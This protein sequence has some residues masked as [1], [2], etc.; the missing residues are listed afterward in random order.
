MYSL[1]HP[2]RDQ[3]V[4]L[5]DPNGKGFAVN[6]ADLI[7]IGRRLNQAEQ[8]QQFTEKIQV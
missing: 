6:I 5:L 1:L 3:K 4:E 7:N 2:K 8:R